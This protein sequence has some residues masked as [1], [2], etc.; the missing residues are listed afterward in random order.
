MAEEIEI[1]GTSNPE[2]SGKFK[3]VSGKFKVELDK[4]VAEFLEDHKSK[5]FSQ[6][7]P[8]L[9]KMIKCQVCLLRHRSS[10]VCE[11]RHVVALTPPEGLTSLT[12][13]QILGR[14]AFKKKRV[15]PHYSKKRLQLVQRTIERFPLHVGLWPSTAEKTAEFVAMQVARREARADLLEIRQAARKTKQSI[16]HRSRRIN[17]GLL[18]GNSRIHR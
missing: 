16:Q 8:E 1:V 14:A 18:Q 7:H 17:R 3:V 12:K 6:R 5:S 11:Q 4:A 13:F 2:L 15:K 10:K 9:G